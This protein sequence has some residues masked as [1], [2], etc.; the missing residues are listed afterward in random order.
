MTMRHTRRQVEAA[1]FA[2]FEAS[3]AQHLRLA[4][5]G[6]IERVIACCAQGDVAA[7]LDQHPFLADYLDMLRSNAPADVSLPGH[8]SRAVRE[9]ERGALQRGARLPLAALREAGLGELQ[10]ELLLAAGLV[11]E[12]PRFGPLFASVQ[13]EERRP[14]FGLLMAWWRVDEEDKDRI[15]D[16]RQGLLDLIRRGFVDVRKGD[17]P[18]PEWVLAVPHALWDA[19]RGEAPR[20]RWLTHVPLQALSGTA[21][22]IPPHP[23]T[24]SCTAL[25]AELRREPHQLLL[26]RGPLHNGRRTLLGCVAQALGKSMLVADAGV[27]EEESRWR[28]F[29]AL[30]VLLDAMPVLRCEL[31]PGEVRNVP[32]MPFTKG[33][34]AIVSSRH[35][36]WSSA[37]GLPVLSITL[38]LPGLE[39]RLAHWRAVLPGQAAG[40]LLPLARAA[41]LTSGDVR[42]AAKAAASFSSLA[43]RDA[44]D[45]GDLQQACRGLQS[46]RL[47]TLATRLPPLPDMQGLCVDDPTRDELDALEARCRLR[48][49]L[50]ASGDGDAGANSGVRVLFAGASGTGKT[51]AAR[52]LAASLGKDLYRIDLAATVNKYLGETEKSLNNAFSAA[53]ELDVVLLLDEGD[54]LMANRTDVGSANDRYANLETNFLLQ[55]VE[56]FDGILVVTSNASDRIDAAFARRMDAVVHFRPPDEWQ[57]YRMLGLHLERDT[58]DDGLLQEIASR[59]ALTGAQIHNVVL[60]ARLLS[61]QSGSALG[62]DQLHA[63]L[64]R[65]YRKIGGHCPLRP[66][67]AAG[68][69]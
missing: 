16:V 66:P 19:L 10:I 39:A 17:C 64:V 27:F 59:C 1:P 6:A 68:A 69:F 46:A 41:R 48:E 14:T 26:V 42:R 9:W 15:E 45:I 51:L 38:P 52:R 62:V 50:A 67:R 25:A 47:E 32:A 60:H 3:P 34:L 63:A 49:D 58:V 12:D 18:R 44:V 29:G 7:A 30:C 33:P 28:L 31:A 13:G 57:R 21:A 5:F 37:E 40:R 54:A 23:S 61:M 53:E 11:E 36:A 20:L 65:E 4:L 22:Y 24:T 8:W 2:R 35:G 43:G 56:S 55:R